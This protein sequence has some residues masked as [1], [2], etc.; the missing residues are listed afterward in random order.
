MKKK[1]INDEILQNKT[2]LGVKL[3]TEA[4]EILHFSIKSRF[5]AILL[6][7]KYLNNYEFMSIII[8]SLL[9]S[10]KLHEED[11]SLKQIIIALSYLKSLY[12]GYTTINVPDIT[13]SDYVNLKEKAIET[14][15]DILVDNNFNVEYDDLYQAFFDKNSALDTCEENFY[16]LN[17]ILFNQNINLYSIVD[18]LDPTIMSKLYEE[19]IQM[20]GRM[21]NI[22]INTKTFVG[23]KRDLSLN[24]TLLKKFL[25][26]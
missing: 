24:S 6:F 13:Y 11:K 8:A 12:D 7:H 3:I 26:H 2:F 19:T 25:N 1:K 22:K 17:T 10:C 5:L 21:K 4:S 14:E 15:L 20:Y 23:K 9:I 16:K 18:L